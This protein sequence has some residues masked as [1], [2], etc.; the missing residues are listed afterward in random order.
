MKP[1]E[2]NSQR[3]QLQPTTK[4]TKV[5][6]N[7]SS[8]TSSRRTGEE[9]TQSNQSTT[10]NQ[11]EIASRLAFEAQEAQKKRT[12]RKVKESVDAGTPLTLKIMEEVTLIL[13]LKDPTSEEKSV[14]QETGDHLFNQ[15]TEETQELINKNLSPEE[16]QA[17]TEKILSEMTILAHLE[18]IG[19]IA[20][21]GFMDF[22]E[23]YLSKL[24]SDI[25]EFVKLKQ[26]QFLHTAGLA[27]YPEEF[28][29]M[30]YLLEKDTSSNN[31]ESYLRTL[32][33]FSWGST[34]HEGALKEWGGKRINEVTDLL[35]DIMTNKELIISDKEF[36]LILKII[37]N[38]SQ[39]S[40][41]TKLSS[42]NKIKNK[43]DQL[44][45][46]R[47]ERATTT[48]ETLKKQHEDNML[49]DSRLSPLLLS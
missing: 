6:A 23:Q 37:N 46:N 36:S 18:C 21:R 49:V 31:L 12:L 22:Y 43:I 34:D 2:T 35:L 33:R 39:I 15:V 32:L 40:L 13:P 16:E 48:Y 1:I 24:I 26:Y 5:R 29:I 19:S 30:Q 10:L 14:L 7:K 42:V 9:K 27:G 41:D 3:T 11:R 45:G 28:D 8:I 20:K 38:F 4:K 25:A 47:K 44:E 17:L